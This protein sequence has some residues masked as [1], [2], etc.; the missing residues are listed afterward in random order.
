MSPAHHPSLDPRRPLPTRVPGDALSY[1]K[2]QE[3]LTACS[4]ATPRDSP[5]PRALGCICVTPCLQSISMITALVSSAL[6]QPEW[7]EDKELPVETDHK[8]LEAI[9]EAL[10]IIRCDSPTRGSATETRQR[11][12]RVPSVTDV[13]CQRCHQRVCYSSNLCVCRSVTRSCLRP[14]APRD[15]G[16]A[17]PSRTSEV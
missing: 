9:Q 2:P 14:D 7:T 13:S 1:S 4:R 16:A 17:K 5:Q 15:V 12:Q 11:Q 8:M 6:L 3:P 10:Q